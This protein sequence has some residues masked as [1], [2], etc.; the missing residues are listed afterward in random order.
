MVN[1]KATSEVK[2]LISKLIWVFI[3]ILLLVSL[4]VSGIVLFQKTNYIL[5]YVDGPSM[6]PTLNNYKNSLYHDCGLVDE[7]ETM[8]KYMERF[9]IVITYY[10]T[11][12]TNGK[13]NRYADKKVKRL[14]GLP[15]EKVHIYTMD[16]VIDDKGTVGKVRHLEIAKRISEEEFGEYVDIPLPFDVYN[17][18]Y[19]GSDVVHSDCEYELGDDEY[20]VVGDNWKQS[21][22][23]SDPVIGAVTKEM[24]T[25]V[26]IKTIGYCTVNSTTKEIEKIYETE[27]KY[28]K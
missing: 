11:D 22:D 6:Y 19:L 13:L 20:F 9:D 12:Y 26:L 23:S 16:E 25:G 27:E 2:I 10:Q 21:R 1:T 17:I 28:F 14:I 3:Y 18:S 24:I 7:S 5:T 8:K 15:N 4:C